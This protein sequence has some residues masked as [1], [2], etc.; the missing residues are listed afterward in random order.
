MKP[1][2]YQCHYKWHIALI[3]AMFLCSGGVAAQ[4]QLTVKGIVTG[5]NDGEPLI[6]VSVVVKGSNMGTVT[7]P[8]GDY[9]IDARTGQ[10]LEF[11][12]IGF[13]T[14]TVKITSSTMDVSMS[15]DFQNL[16]EVVVVGYGTMKRSDLTGSVSSVT[17]QDIKKTVSVSLDQALQGRAAGVAVTQN[18]GAPGGGISVS[19][20]GTNSL[21]GNEPLYVVDGI[22]ISGDIGDHT[23][24]LSNINPADIVSM[25]VLKDASASAIYGSRASNGVILITTRRGQIGKPK[26][27]YE[28]YFALQQLPKKLEVLNLREFAEYRNAVCDIMGFGKNSY[29][30]DPSILGE[31]TDWQGELFRT[32]PM[33]SHQVSLSGGSENIQY[34]VSGAYLSQEGIAIGS[35]FDRF[36]ARVNLDSK[37]TKWLKIGINASGAY[38]KQTNTIDNNGIIEVAI[39]QLP[40]TPARNPDGSF[41]TQQPNM[42]GRY[43]ANPIEQALQREN[44][45]KNTDIYANVFGEIQFMKGL[46]LRVEYGGN[47]YYRFN[48]AYTPE[49]DYETYKQPSNGSRSARNGYSTVFKTFVNF[50]R[51]FGRH[52]VGAM[53]GHESQERGWE[54]LSGSRTGYL[55][56][57]I[58]DLD[59]GDAKS[60]KNN[61]SHS[62]WAMESYFGRVNYTY[63]NR[64]LLTA[65]FR[66]DGSSNLGK[67]NRWGT[68]PSIALAWRVSNESFMKDIDWINGLKVRF[69]YGIVG[70]QNTPSF[71]YGTKMKSISSIWGTGFYSENY[72]NS[73]L[74]WEETKAYNA[75]IDINLFQNRI[76]LI[77]DAYKKNTDNLLMS[78]SLPKYV[79][80]VISSPYV[81]A[82][83]MENKGF[84]ITLNTV[85]I[86]SHDF[87]W[88]S[89]ITFSLNRN[90]VTKLYTETT[91]ISGVLTKTYTYTV[92]GQPVGQFFGYK[93]L[94]MFKSEDDFYKKDAN[95][96]PIYDDAGN[97]IPVALPKDM[98]VGKDKIWVGDYM[99]YDKNGDGVIDESD[100]VFLGN[101]E[102]KFTFG[103]DNTFVYKDIDLNIFV[104][105]VVG[106]KVFNYLRSAY[107]NPGYSGAFKDARNF[108]QV[109]LIDPTGSD[110][111]I[112]NVYVSNDN[113]STYRITTVNSNDND[114]ISDLSI[115][116]GSYVRIKNISLGY[117][118]PKKLLSKIGIEQLRLYA[119]VQNA[120]TFTNYKGYDPEVGSYKQNVLLRGIDNARYPTQRIW[121]MGVNLNF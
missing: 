97:R 57:T 92:A 15:E 22:P 35:K 104:T 4:Q 116:D 39:K 17:D 13:I 7:G 1:S 55:F 67:N 45:N 113:P 18:S 5:Q 69:G 16:D 87:T 47:F 10:T 9:I 34:M 111:D 89:G 27:S 90:K 118:F 64:Y 80:G 117:S 63:D 51:D 11:R 25:E 99:W 19:I 107:L 60:A 71:A 91:G 102:P 109:G 56:N 38:S 36:S 115:E 28:G 70:N 78:A 2:Y 30:A 49:Y 73:N 46:S 23:N 68:F 65:T 42:F 44:D 29:H 76:E 98:E 100:R 120:F 32:A 12:Y 43:Y 108:A 58:H 61:N 79:N 106:N 83:A 119:N 77:I 72:S 84:D 112:S 74:K 93:C 110:K 14:K 66:A 31:G 50:N 37:P 85:N 105:G 52:S 94:G 53:I 96:F 54:S 26:F 20:R 33:H 48:Y 86:D 82:G 6:G 88:R 3:I 95:G 114:R 8:D 21:N 121:T 81:N 75:G 24:A 62:S 103:F 101:P 40:D 59:A 41:G